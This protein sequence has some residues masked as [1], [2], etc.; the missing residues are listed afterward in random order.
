MFDI[1][2][3]LDSCSKIN[4]SRFTSLNKY[5]STW[6]SGILYMFKTP[7]RSI[8]QRKLDTRLTLGKL[9]AGLLNIRCISACL[10]V[11]ENSVSHSAVLQAGFSQT[12]R[13]RD[14]R[15]DS[16]PRL[17]NFNLFS[18]RGR[19]RIDQGYSCWERR[20]SHS[21][22]AVFIDTGRCHSSFGKMV[23]G[24]SEW[25]TC[26][27]MMTSY[28]WPTTFMSYMISSQPVMKWA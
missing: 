1:R 18:H 22:Q 4:V 21:P 7:S 16:T 23:G 9:S 15:K 5:S 24:E 12:R 10:L 6:S 8:I 19:Q 20:R 3:W 27:S 11:Y 14:L 28:R 2:T 17:R 25:T 13:K 26:V